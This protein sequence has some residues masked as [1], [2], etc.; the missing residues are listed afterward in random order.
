MRLHII[1]YFAFSFLMITSQADAKKRKTHTIKKGDTLGAVAHKYK[2]P[3]DELRRFNNLTSSG[4]FKVGET[5]EIPFKGEVTGSTYTV[6]SSD[7]VARVAD[8]HGV[9]QSDLRRANG[10]SKN[11][12]LTVGKKIKIPSTLRNGAARGHVVR[13]GDTLSL[14]AKEH[15]VKVKNLA[16]ANKLKRTSALKLGRTLIIPDEEDDV[17]NYKPK[18]SSKLVITSK[19]VPGGILHTVQPGQSL[20]II[21]RA[22]NVRGANIAKS[23]GISTGTQLKTGQKILIPGAKK[24]VPVRVKGFVIQPI[25]FVRVWNNKS[26]TVRLMTNSGKINQRSRKKLSRLSGPRKKSKRRIKRFHPRLLHMIQRVAERW[27]GHT[28]EI[29]SGYRAHEKGKESRH[30]QGRAVDFRVKG[31]SNKDLYNFCTQLP[32]SGCGYYPNSV[33]IHMDARTE[34]T[35]WT[36]ISA[37]GEKPHYTQ[38]GH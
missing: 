13:K 19:K 11:D 25:R 24:A 27:P 26:I 28:L 21:A 32:K 37:P 2:V 3:L 33:F 8:F 4:S 23:N 30:A 20:W 6:K 10:M 18:K 1:I 9:S 38:T 36:D 16:A 31:I 5:I 7:S 34:S 29:V 12:R 35:T 17:G 22:Y 15:H 14:V